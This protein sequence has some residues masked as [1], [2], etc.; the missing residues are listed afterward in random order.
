MGMKYGVAYNHR[1]DEDLKSNFARISENDE[2]DFDELNSEYHNR[3]RA[4]TTNEVMFL[5][6]LINIFSALSNLLI[7]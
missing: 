4:I 7:S 6:Y 2:Y 3:E 5:P 1:K